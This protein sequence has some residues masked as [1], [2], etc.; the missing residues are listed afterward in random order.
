MP[1]DRS[2]RSAPSAGIA[3]ISGRYKKN[4]RFVVHSFVKKSEPS[5]RDFIPAGFP[6]PLWNAIKFSLMTLLGA[7]VFASSPA[8][9]ANPKNAIEPIIVI[10]SKKSIY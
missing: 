7:S 5:L 3:G 4:D 6:L 10:I 1:G 9:V 8:A 2:V